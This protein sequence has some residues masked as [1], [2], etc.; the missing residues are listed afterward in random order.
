MA[1]D[2]RP[3]PATARRS[4][5]LMGRARLPGDKSISHR[6]LMLG[7]LAIGETRITGLL[8]CEDVMRTAA[9]MR[10]L[11]AE[12]ERGRGGVW[13]RQG[14]GNG[15]LLEPEAPLDFGN[16]GTGVAAGDG[17]GRRPC[18]R[19]HLRRRRLA[20]A[21]ADG[22]R[23]RAAARDGR[24]GGRGRSGDRLPLTIRGPK[25]AAPIVY[26]VP[27]PSAQVKSAVLL[28]GLNTPG[29]T[30]VDRAGGD[31]RPYRAD[32]AG[33][34]RRHRG[35]DRPRRRRHHPPRRAGPSWPARASR[36]PAIRAPPP[37]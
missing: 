32:A 12:V 3:Q 25:A 2:H 17:A 36:C 8:E 22:P 21:S 7:A 29:I 19:H 27:V 35:R 30:T 20:V 9:A 4:P 13:A 34:R 15:G 14:S 1:H 26:R 31:A 5:P 10:A 16:A 23:A 18:F 6:S 37:S 24:A 28:A 11:G 33:L